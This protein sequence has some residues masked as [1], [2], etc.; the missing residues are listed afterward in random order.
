MPIKMTPVKS[1]NIQAIGYDAVNKELHVQFTSGKTYAYY[2]VT[3]K[4]HGEFLRAYTIGSHFARHIRP[5]F[6]GKPV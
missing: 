1:S 5:H 3:P 4:Q 2:G 6:S